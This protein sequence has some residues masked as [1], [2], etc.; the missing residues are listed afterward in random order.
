VTLPHD[1]PLNTHKYST[2]LPS[3][4][5]TKTRVKT[6]PKTENPSK[7]PFKNKFLAKDKK[8]VEDYKQKEEVPKSEEDKN[9]HNTD[10]V[11][12]HFHLDVVYFD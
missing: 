9:E 12:T 1:N 7:N 3:P 2:Q 10:V 6:P 8:V 4:K 5:S 11:N